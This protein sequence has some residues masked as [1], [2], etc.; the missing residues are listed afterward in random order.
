[1]QI[2]RLNRD[3]FHDQEEKKS[4]KSSHIVRRN[5]VRNDTTT[6][7]KSHD[8]NVNQRNLVWKARKPSLTKI[9]KNA[10][11]QKRNSLFY[12]SSSLVR[13]HQAFKPKRK[14]AQ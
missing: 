5:I 13:L 12:L 14:C 1:M 4:E 2:A 3:R 7:I 8:T 9:W 6:W 10:T 11:E